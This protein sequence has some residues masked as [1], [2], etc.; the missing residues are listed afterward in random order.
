MS[1]RCLGEDAERLAISAL[2]RDFEPL[3][4]RRLALYLGC[5]TEKDAFDFTKDEAGEVGRRAW[6]W[7]I[8]RARTVLT[9]KLAVGVVTAFA[10][11]AVA[12]FAFPVFVAVGLG[13]VAAFLVVWAVQSQRLLHRER[14]AGHWRS[15]DILRA[16]QRELRAQVS[17]REATL[18]VAGE[19][20]DRE[21]AMRAYQPLVA[22]VRY[23]EA[24]MRAALKAEASPRQRQR[25]DAA[26]KAPDLGPTRR[27][28]K[29]LREKGELVEARIQALAAPGT[30]WET[31]SDEKAEEYRRA[32]AADLEARKR[33]RK[34]QR[35]TALAPGFAFEM[36]RNRDGS[37]RVAKRNPDPTPEQISRDEDEDA[38]AA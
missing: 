28:L 8:D 7:L 14:S 16:H 6:H 17:I 21:A 24:R 25:S 33:A 5:V 19:P 1:W 18:V 13:V 12:A 38:D 4:S 20:G 2:W 22:A 34:G 10:F 15:I 26:P 11:A 9:V 31:K 27:E 30:E 3:D 35:P 23:R 29:E 37:Q 32:R 36:G